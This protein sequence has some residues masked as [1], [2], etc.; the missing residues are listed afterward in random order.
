MPDI[1]SMIDMGMGACYSH[2]NGLE[3][4]VPGPKLA[5]AKQIQ[6]VDISHSDKWAILTLHSLDKDSLLRSLKCIGTLRPDIQY[7][8]FV[9]NKCPHYSQ[10]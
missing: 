1:Q 8:Q 3:V 9:N 10:S 7:E 5:Q 4:D 6:T 2:G